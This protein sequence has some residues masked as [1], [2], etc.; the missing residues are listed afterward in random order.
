VGIEADHVTVGQYRKYRR[1]VGKGLKSIKSL[2][3]PL[4]ACKDSYELSRIKKAV[5]IA[6]DAMRALLEWFKMD[7]TERELAARLEYEMSRRHS[8]A[9]GFETIVAVAGHAAQPHA[10]PGNTRWKKNQPIL[11]D[12]GATFAGYKSDLTRCFVAGKIRPAFAEAY[13][14]LLEA[15]TSAIE[16]VRPGAFLKA[17]DEIAR[18]SLLK[19]P[20]PIYGHG[21][22]HGIGLAVHEQPFLGAKSKG[23][24]REGMVITVEPGI[25]IPGRFGVRIE[26][27]VLV[28]AGGHQILSTLAKDL[29]SCVIA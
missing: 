28:T 7:M 13:Q 5:R 20:F 22:G 11:F 6:E 14:W 16:A 21:S 19:S 27:D 26:D 15:Q 25:Y 18:K 1:A 23:R 17:I 10:K 29:D 12:W 2:V 3:A 24:L 9:A 4:R 8:T